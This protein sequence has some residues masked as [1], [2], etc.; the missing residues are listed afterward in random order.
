MLPSIAA[1]A[2]VFRYPSIVYAQLNPNAEYLYRFKPCV[3]SSVSA[4]YAPQSTPAFYRSTQAPAMIDLSIELKEIELWTRED[5]NYSGGN[6]RITNPFPE[7]PQIPI[8]PPQLNQPLGANLP[9]VL[10][11]PSS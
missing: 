11:A 8:S 10:G 5:Y 9:A 7:G 1:G 4:N 3:I 2:A 6:F